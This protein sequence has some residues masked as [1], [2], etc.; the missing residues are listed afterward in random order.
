MFKTKLSYLRLVIES[1]WIMHNVSEKI[2]EHWSWV[3]YQVFREVDTNDLT[4]T[5]YIYAYFSKQNKPLNFNAMR[6]CTP[7]IKLP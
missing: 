7:Y 3:L 5:V 6:Y 1:F 2:D 4:G